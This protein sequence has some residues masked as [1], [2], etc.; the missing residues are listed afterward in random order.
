MVQINEFISDACTI[1]SDYFK[2]IQ[3]DASLLKY[4]PSIL[5]AVCFMIGFQQQFEILMENDPPIID[6]STN[7][8][9]QL[10]QM[11]SYTFQQWIEILIGDLKIEQL[12]KILEFTG[13]V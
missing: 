12:E 5:A 11:I 13:T 8:G 2:S 9:K 3:I 10:T 1:A 6:L 7:S 4:R